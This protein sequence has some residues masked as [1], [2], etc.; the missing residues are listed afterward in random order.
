MLPL[1]ISACQYFGKQAVP[2]PDLEI[3]GGGGGVNQTLRKW[4]RGVVLAKKFSAIRA[5]V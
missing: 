3:R 4:G 2:D 1:E 5:S